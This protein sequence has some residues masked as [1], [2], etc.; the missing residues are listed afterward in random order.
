MLDT[1][2]QSWTIASGTS[3]SSLVLSGITGY[4][5]FVIF[6]IRGTSPTGSGNWTYN[7]SLSQFEILSGSSE[8]ITGGQPIKSDFNRYI[9][10]HNWTSTTFLSES[11]GVYMYSFASDPISALSTG[12][13]MSG[14]HFQ[15]SEQL[16]LTFSSS[17]SSAVQVDLWAPAYSAIEA[18]GQQFKKISL[19]G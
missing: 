12:S 9:L 14:F 15:G 5:P 3:S 6:S 18:N 13:N 19:S 17:L 11:A 2:T 1:R 7:T 16:K 8:N 4:V 10:G